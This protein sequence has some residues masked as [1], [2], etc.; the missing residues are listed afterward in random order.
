MLFSPFF[1]RYQTLAT[2]TDDAKQDNDAMSMSGKR[3]IADWVLGLGE[4]IMEEKFDVIHR[5]TMLF[6]FQVNTLLKFKSFQVAL[7][8]IRHVK[9]WS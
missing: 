3:I 8:K 2:A 1:F 5:N 4:Y 9:L 6:F 7:Q